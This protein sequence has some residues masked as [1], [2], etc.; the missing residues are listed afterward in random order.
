MTPEM[1][2]VPALSF[3]LALIMAWGLLLP[4]VEGSAESLSP[5]DGEERREERVQA[6]LLRK[7]TALTELEELEE[8]RV[9]KRISLADYEVSKG[10]LTEIAGEV[11]TAIAG[12][13]SSEI[14]PSKN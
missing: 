10:E 4:Y 1:L 6:L 13:A 12:E 5:N 7:E 3:L 8:D 2:V 11:F 14:K 9:T